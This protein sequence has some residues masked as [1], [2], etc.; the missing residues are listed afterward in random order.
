MDSAME[1]LGAM[2]FVVVVYLIALAVAMIPALLY[3]AASVVANWFLF[4]KAGRPGWKAL[5]PYY[6]SWVMY[7]IICGEGYKMFFLF[8]P[9]FNIYWGI[10]TYIE[11]AH[12]YGKSTGFGVAMYLLDPIFRL[13]IAFD[14]SAYLGPRELPF[15]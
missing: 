14:K 11:L 4:R 2:G 12:A 13:V 8:I 9:Y 3:A 7:D 10:V 1:S 5:I 15:I 6:N